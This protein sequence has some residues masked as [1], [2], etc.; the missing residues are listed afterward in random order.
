MS[1]FTRI[2][3]KA[4][5]ETII[6]AVKR[7]ARTSAGLT[8]GLLVCGAIASAQTS[9]LKVQDR[10]HD[11]DNPDNQ[12][13]AHYEIDNTGT[14]AVPLTSLTMRY[15]FTNETPSDPL[16]FACD[17]AQVNCSN[18][19]TKFVVLSP[20]RHL[21][22][23]YLE[24]SFTAAAG[25]IPAGGQTGEIQTRI[26][27]QNYSNFNTTETYSFISDPSFVYKDTNTVTLYRNGVLVWGIEPSVGAAVAS[28]AVPT[29]A[30]VNAAA[31]AK[32]NVTNVTSNSVTLSFPGTLDAQVANVDILNGTSLVGTATGNPVTVNG[33]QPST[34]LT[35][36]GRTRDFAGNPLA[37]TAPTAVTT[38]AATSTLKVQDRSHDNDDPDNQLYA[39]YEIDNTGTAAVPLSSLKMR[40]WLTN[41]NPTDPLVFACDY[42]LVTCANITSKFVVLSPSRNLANTY[43]EIGFTA[44]AGSIAPG[45]NSGEIQ[46]RIHHP[47]YLNFI[48]H[49]TYSFISDPSFVYKDT[50]TVTLYQNGSLVWGVEPQ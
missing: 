13:Y 24:I 17:Y 6:P 8:V 43:L 32:L 40:Y 9:G 31:T 5:R 1:I 41:N 33:L 7:W 39:H 49:Q 30:K 34:T 16:V 27:H 20:T 45:K 21:A 19:T 4:S 36:T 50:K 42:A 18:I 25:S 15:W 35:L 48:T 2:L 10:S 37:T 23:T 11:N 46:T 47:D 12:L 44:A 3:E 14:A 28:P 22:N 26:H 29:N 38:A